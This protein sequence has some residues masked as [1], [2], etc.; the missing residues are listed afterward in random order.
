M[1]KFI[2]HYGSVH[3]PGQFENQKHKNSVD[4]SEQ[5]PM[6]KQSKPKIILMGTSNT[7]HIKPEKWSKY[8]TEK[9][10]TYTIKEAKEKLLQYVS[11]DN[12]IPSV[13]VYHVLANDFKS[14]EASQCV[15]RMS[16]LINVSLENFPNTKIIASLATPRSDNNE[17]NNNTELINVMLKQKY[18]NHDKVYLSDNSNIGVDGFPK[19]NMI[20]EDGYHLTSEGV[21]MLVANIKHAI[22][23]VSQAS[24]D[25]RGSP[26]RQGGL[27][28]RDNF[29]RN[30]REDY[31]HRGG[32]FSRGGSQGSFHRYN[33][34]R[35]NQGGNR[36]DISR[37]GPRLQRL[38]RW[39]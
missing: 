38:G 29:Q 4:I 6:P 13:I 37:V 27:S 7:E 3:A 9:E 28:Y 2:Y 11:S 26:T 20:H 34:P 18:R 21:A 10:T 25:S 8:M 31:S 36:G 1:L 33:N 23:R 35:Y 39:D 17:W 22:D 32:Y 19:K 24:G 12:D 5:Q 15:N 30:R 16:D 14:M